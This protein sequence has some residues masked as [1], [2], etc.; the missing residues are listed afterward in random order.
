MEGYTDLGLKFF[1][2]KYLSKD[3]MDILSEYFHGKIFR[4]GNFKTDKAKIR[5]GNWNQIDFNIAK[6]IKGY[7]YF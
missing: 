6:V 2:K 3:A 7:Y 4:L 1:K 5:V